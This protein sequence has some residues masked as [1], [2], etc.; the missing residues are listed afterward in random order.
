L[1]LAVLIVLV[2]DI[3]LPPTPA[4]QAIHD[5]Y[6]RAASFGLANRTAVLWAGL[7]TALLTLPVVGLLELREVFPQ[8]LAP[9][10]AAITIAEIVPVVIGAVWFARLL[11]SGISEGLADSSRLSETAPVVSG[12]TLVGGVKVILAAGVYI[13]PL[14]TLP[15]LPLGL[16]AAADKSKGRFTHPLSLLHLA[17]QRPQDLIV[18]WLVLLMWG[19]ATG[20]GLGAVGMLHHYAAGMT[21]PDEGSTVAYVTMVSMLALGLAG[22]VACVFGLAIGHCIGT[23][24]RRQ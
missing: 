10:S 1:V 3:D 12:D 8:A 5:R 2:A 16:L 19:A 24:G 4:R 14:L 15:L 6:F 21:F 11:A 17:R 23:F 9:W 13:V 18:L 7:L 22:A 20:L